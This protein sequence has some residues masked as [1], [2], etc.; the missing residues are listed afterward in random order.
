MID[1]LAEDN[2][3]GAA[4]A[5]KVVQASASQMS[6]GAASVEVAG[7][8]K[9]ADGAASKGQSK[10]NEA[11]KQPEYNPDFDIEKLQAEKE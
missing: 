8:N 9:D 10:P 3:K 11:K 6:A 4:G 1:K 2:D 7:A 5:V